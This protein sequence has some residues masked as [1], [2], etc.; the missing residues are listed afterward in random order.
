LGFGARQRSLVEVVCLAEI[1]NPPTGKERGQREF[2][3]DDQFSPL[4][5]GLFEEGD[6]PLHDFGAAVR[7][8]NWP[9]LRSCN[10]RDA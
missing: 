6:E 7:S 3:E 1:I 4:R 9:K 2:W 8:L 5:T 10:S